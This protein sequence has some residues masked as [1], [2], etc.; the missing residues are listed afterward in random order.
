M[1]RPTISY[2]EDDVNISVGIDKAQDEGNSYIPALFIT[3]NGNVFPVV[4]L[5]EWVKVSNL[6]SYL[7]DD[8]S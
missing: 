4:T 8:E 6:V 1:R 3:V 5:D 7:L 2:N